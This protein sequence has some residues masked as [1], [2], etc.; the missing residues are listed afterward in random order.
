MDSNHEPV[1]LAGKEDLCQMMYGLVTEVRNRIL[2]LT[3]AL[4]DMEGCHVVSSCLKLTWQPGSCTTARVISPYGGIAE[5]IMMILE[6]NDEED[7]GKNHLV[8]PP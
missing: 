7:L 3:G 5:I 4:S 8:F 6:D 2:A 1:L